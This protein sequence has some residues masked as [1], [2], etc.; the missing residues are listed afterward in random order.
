[1]RTASRK[2]INEFLEEEC[3]RGPI[4]KFSKLFFYSLFDPDSWENDYD[5]SIKNIGDKILKPCHDIFPKNFFQA[6]K[7]EKE[8]HNGCGGG[9]FTNYILSGCLKNLIKSSGSSKTIRVNMRQG[10]SDLTVGDYKVEIKR[11]S[12]T[13]IDDIVSD[14]RSKI[15]RYNAHLKWAI[16]FL[17]PVLENEKC[18]RTQHLVNGYKFLTNY[19]KLILQDYEVKV[20]PKVVD[21]NNLEEVIKNVDYNT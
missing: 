9:D 16:L 21:E 10:E 2:K 19:F 15:S 17:F 6:K 8:I 11:L 7:F 13:N 5:I 4:K 1:M 20:I 12:V 14:I 18:E 3:E